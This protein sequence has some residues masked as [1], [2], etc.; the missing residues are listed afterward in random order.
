MGQRIEDP[1]KFVTPSPNKYKPEEVVIDKTPEHAF[2]IKHSPYLGKLKGDAWVAART[3]VVTPPTLVTKVTNGDTSKTVKTVVNGGGSKT[4]TST[5]T[6]SD[7]QKIRTETFTY[8]KG[9]TTRITT[10]TTS[11]QVTQAAA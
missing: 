8:T 10:T 11:Q 9:P 5:R 2:G 6:H 4:T 3:E 7:G 1:A